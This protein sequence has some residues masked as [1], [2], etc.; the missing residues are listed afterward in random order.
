MSEMELWWGLDTS[1]GSNDGGKEVSA[2]D[3]VRVNES[4]G[5]ARKY[6]GKIAWSVATNSKVAAFISFLFISIDNDEF[7]DNL[8]CFVVPQAIGEPVFLSKIFVACM[9]PL[10]PE[11]ADELS[12]DKEFQL[13]YH[14][15]ISFQSY[16]LYIQQ[17]FAHDN[18][19]RKADE[20][21]LKEFL[22][23]VI[24]LWAITMAE[25]ESLE[26]TKVLNSRSLE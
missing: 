3:I 19:A 10:Y 17:V 24:E 18:E 5:E 12:L 16:L 25:H 26:N 1:I 6:R 15:L 8:G 7:R 11:K 4:L 21:K 13:D 22:R 2:E 14:F 20:K 23:V 9:L